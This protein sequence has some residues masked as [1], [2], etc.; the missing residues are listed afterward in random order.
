[1]PH[2]GIPELVLILA[3][4]LI[5]LG[6]SRLPQLGKALGKTI[7]TYRNEMRDDAVP[8]AKRA[9]KAAAAAGGPAGVD[10]GN[11][12]WLQG[13]LRKMLPALP[14]YLFKMFLRRVGR[15]F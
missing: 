12:G 4:I 7:S 14:G 13:L 3:V 6:P 9:G 10:T 11:K 5:F 2:L 8:A 1:M 15:F